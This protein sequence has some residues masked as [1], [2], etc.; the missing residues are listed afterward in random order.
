[1]VRHPADPK[2]K[3]DLVVV[4]A[5]DD[6]L[7][8][9]H[10]RVLDRQQ[11]GMFDLEV[12]EEALDPGLIGRGSG[13]AE[14][15]S[16]R[17]QRHE[18]PGRARGHLRTVV[19]HGEQHR[20][21]LV[22]DVDAGQP[23]LDGGDL[24]EQPLG[25]E[26]V[27]EHDLDLGGGLLGRDG[28][29]LWVIVDS[30]R[31]IIRDRD[32]LPA[33]EEILSRVLERRDPGRLSAHQ[34]IADSHE[35]SSLARLGAIFEDAARTATDLWLRET[36]TERGL[37]G[38][39]DDSEWP[40]LTGRVRETAL[41]GHDVAALIDEAIRMRPIED[42]HSTAAVLHWRLGILGATP[43][44]GPRGPLASLPP[45]DGPAIDVAH[46]A[47]ELMRQR[48]R[49]LRAALAATTNPL[50]WAQALGTPPPD[51]DA[52]SAWLTATTAVTA[53]R[54]RF[55]IPDHTPMLGPRPAASRPDAQAAWNHACLQ[56]DRYLA[57]R[58]HHLDDQQLTDLDAHQQ[59]IIDDPPPFDPAELQQ[60]RHA[61]S[62]TQRGVTATA[63]PGATEA[64][65]HAHLRVARLERAAQAHLDWRRTALEAADLRRQIALE[66]QQ[67]QR[68]P[69][70]RSIPARTA[71]QSP[72]CSPSRAR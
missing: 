19:G 58:L 69:T 51:P 63:V 56:A 68:R 10:G 18:L 22:I 28:N 3:A 57:R 53:Y 17:G 33:P 4:P 29:H 24:I 41:A 14:V 62:Q 65:G 23:V 60:A 49:E 55:D 52:K 9:Q 31:D 40:A 47:G 37:E 32:D 50:P 71:R 42:A 43:A 38:A 39:I 70:Q 13:P 5:A 59:T 20:T 21:G 36:L 61:L 30:D 1:M 26:R 6:E 34:T 12:A 2:R 46:Q 15:L 72:F 48:W 8:T 66:Q 45:T 54:E 11:V 16:D 64:A 27:G 35:L 7:G 67:R 25:F 44:P